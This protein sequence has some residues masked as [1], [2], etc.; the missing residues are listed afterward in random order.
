MSQHEQGKNVGQNLGESMGPHREPFISVENLS[1]AY[2]GLTVIEAMSLQ[3]M[4]K[5]ITCILGASGCGK[6]SFLKVLA[7]F[8]H[9]SSGV[10]KVRKKIISSPYHLLA[11]QKRGMGMSF[12]DHALFPHLSVY[13]NIVLG[14]KSKPP[15]EYKQRLEHIVHEL[16]L[17]SLLQK[18][19][20]SISG[21][22]QQRCSL[23][24]ALLPA[25]S[26][27]LLDEPLASQDV[28]LKEKLIL[29]L[30]SLIKE[31]GITALLVT[32]D[33]QEAFYM[34][35]RM[36]FLHNKRI[37]QFSTPYE[38]YHRPNSLW[39]AQ[40]I[41]KGSFLAGEITQGMLQTELGTIKNFRYVPLNKPDTS[42]M[43]LSH[44]NVGYPKPQ[45]KK[46]IKVFFRPSETQ[47]DS[48]SAIRGKITAVFFQ[49]DSFL[50]EIILPSG[51]K[52]LSQMSSHY[53]YALGEAVGLRI[54]LQN[55]TAFES[56]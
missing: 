26:I 18:Y 28:E 1:F 34:A 17:T 39:T 36:G 52:V 9:P 33:Q 41:G 13:E 51:A 2:K 14:M 30:R 46:Q 49:G 47:I 19:P 55:L 43:L 15:K 11:P 22:E 7:G 24:R 38:M 20:N 10:I 48:R 54:R 5:E 53:K 50:Y 40:F 56:G 29:K 3:V 32:H 35:D 42:S 27:L 25:P 23:A 12:Q 6:T 45:E 37:I 16:K 21:G 8:I 31:N 44:S 4:P